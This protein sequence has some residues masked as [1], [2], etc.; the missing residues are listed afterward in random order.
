[1]NTAEPPDT[2]QA[3]SAPDRPDTRHHRPIG[4]RSGGHRGANRGGTT[5]DL[6]IIGLVA[7]LLRI[8]AFLARRS[9]V[10]DDGVFGA[11]VV[12]MRAGSAPFREV[13]SSQGPLFLPLAWVGDLVAL[14]MS[15]SPRALAVM[16]GVAIA[17]A[18]YVAARELT[19][20]PRALLAAGLVI[21]SGSVLWTTAPLTADGPAGALSVIAVAVALVYRRSPSTGRAIAIGIL[22]GAA[23]SVKS[24]LVLPAFVTIGIVIV[25]RRRRADILG[26][27]IVAAT[28]V[29][30]ASIP[31]GLARVLEQSVLYH[32]DVVGERAPL[33]NLDVITR[34][35]ATR[36]LPLVVA[37]GV[38]VFG[39]LWHR[40]QRDRSGPEDLALE[41][42]RPNGW[43]ERLSSGRAPIVVW[44]ILVVGLLLSE[45]PLWR[46]HV[47]HLVPPLALLVA[48]ARV[49]WR[50]LA[51]AAVV[52]VPIWAISLQP[53][54][55][56]E[57]AN[58]TEAT[59][60]RAIRSLPP[61]AMVISD[62]PGIVWRNGR[63]TPDRFVDPSILRITSPRRGI[64]ITEGDVV[65]DAASPRVCGVVRW[66]KPRFGSFTHLGARLRREGYE[67]RYPNLPAPRAVWLKTRCRPFGPPPPAWPDHPHGRASAAVGLDRSAD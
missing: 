45:N 4:G 54:L 23:F 6:V 35:L 15:D 29:V 43:V 5:V 65:R 63:R 52:A 40:T 60:G 62:E 48:T 55:W 33:H 67:R 20:R 26:V 10:F 37:G 25:S 3:V 9:L 13:F 17:L 16:S 28:I 51:I 47:A 36:D 21:V 61:G 57:G 8:P 34:A 59:I 27:P 44:T 11:S 32:T 12:A 7:L 19:T 24:L 14:R 2:R 50:T 22:A 58:A 39:W 1:V 31:W 38:A 64:R 46:S 30:V 42:T 56:P 49:R 41:A 53:L 66:S 18:T